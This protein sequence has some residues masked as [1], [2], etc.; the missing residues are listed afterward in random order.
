MPLTQAFA[1][2]VNMVETLR[3]IGVPLSSAR[4]PP[5]FSYLLTLKQ[6][7]QVQ[8][9]CRREGWS[10][11][12]HRG[13]EITLATVDHVYDARKRKDNC[14][15]AFIVS[16]LSAAYSDRSNVGVNKIHDSQVLIFNALKSLFL[17]GQKFHALAVVQANER[18]GKKYL[19]AVTAYHANEAKIRKI[20]K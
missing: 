19:S 6:Q 10:V 9:I 4:H 14:D 15:T 1:E 16:I 2:L 7:N 11:P 17:N 8:V 12:A 20:G 18:N 13:I 3:N 5:I